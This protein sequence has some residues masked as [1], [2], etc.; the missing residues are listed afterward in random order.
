MC[1]KMVEYETQEGKESSFN[2]D[3][4]ARVSRFTDWRWHR[5]HCPFLHQ[6][7]QKYSNPCFLVSM[8]NM[9]NMLTTST[10][11]TPSRTPSCL[12]TLSP[13]SLYPHYALHTKL[14]CKSRSILKGS[15]IISFFLSS[16]SYTNTHNHCM[17]LCGVLKSA[18]SIPLTSR[19]RPRLRIKITH[20]I[21]NLDNQRRST[22]PPTQITESDRIHVGFSKSTSTHTWLY[23]RWN[24]Y[25]EP[26]KHPHAENKT[27]EVTADKLRRIQ[28]CPFVQPWDCY[29]ITTNSTIYVYVSL[30]FKFVTFCS[31]QDREN[32]ECFH[33]SR[34]EKA[35]TQPPT[36]AQAHKHTNTEEASLQSSTKV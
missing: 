13:F 34:A 5:R 29:V 20:H 1:R 7:T 30:L 11:H 22:S 15:V 16:T 17:R 33:P 35:H 21:P 32:A 31:L 2:Q 14:C 3:T 28:P 6:S 9:S 10:A 19:F 8:S 25:V 36:Q 23:N 4:H 27:R 18:F 24:F 26:H 12:R